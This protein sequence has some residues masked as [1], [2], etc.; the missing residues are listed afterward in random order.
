MVV[1][2]AAC[3]ACAPRA[4]SPGLDYVALGDSVAADPGV[5]EPAP[6]QGC[7]K[8]TNNYPSVFARRLKVATFIDA[9]CSGA[10]TDNVLSAAQQTS[11]GLVD[12]QIESV[13]GTTDLVTITIGAN[14][15]ELITELRQ[16]E[17]KTPDPTPCQDQFVVGGV[18]RVAALTA[19]HAPT[20]AAVINRVRVR[21]PRARI[22]L[23]GYGI[24]LRPGGCFPSQPVLPQDADYLQAKVDGLDEQQRKIASAN[25]V[26]YFDT[27][28]LHRGHDMCAAPAD[29]YVNGYA[30]EDP[31][32][33]LHPTPQGAAAVG[34][35]LADSA[36]RH[37]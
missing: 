37:M 33:P 21:A 19:A 23:V 34:E 17:V 6:P 30:T 5:P 14:D 7:H 9:T 20:W 27:R 26:E 13:S 2:G 18:D 22:I 10:T 25:G 11:T 15:I 32:V 4:G 35:A 3:L 16:C 24:L 8:S 36:G 28:P 31:A 29:R 12:P 1:L